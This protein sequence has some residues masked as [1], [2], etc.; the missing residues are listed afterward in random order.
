MHSHMNVKFALA[1][2][3]AILSFKMNDVSIRMLWNLRAS[4]VQIGC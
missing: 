2:L 1:V 4:S 3:Y